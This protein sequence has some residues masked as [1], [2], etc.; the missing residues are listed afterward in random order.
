MDF[1]PV[2]DTRYDAHLIDA[3]FP[4]IDL[5]ISTPASREEAA[6][7]AEQ[8]V[9]RKRLIVSLDS[10]QHHFHDSLYIVTVRNLTRYLYAHPTGDGGTNLVGINQQAFNFGRGNNI[11]GIYLNSSTLF[12]IESNSRKNAIQVACCF[13][14]GS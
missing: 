8:P 14:Y 10:I 7:P 3:V 6:V 11:M 5:L 9:I 1:L 2:K 4:H 13:V 12:H